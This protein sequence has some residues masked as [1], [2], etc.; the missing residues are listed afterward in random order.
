M[1][2]DKELEEIRRKLLE[3]E[4]EPPTDG[5]KNIKAEV[6]PPDTGWRPIGWFGVILLLL[7]ATLGVYYFLN[8][9]PATDVAAVPAAQEQQ[10]ETAAVVESGKNTVTMQQ[11]ERTLPPPNRAES[12][13]PASQRSSTKAPTETTQQEPTRLR[14]QPQEQ[15]KLPG[16][17]NDSTNPRPAQAEGFPVLAEVQDT[18]PQE[19][20]V[21]AKRVAA[22]SIAMVEDAISTG[23]IP[24]T[25]KPSPE[26]E[27]TSPKG[28]EAAAKNEVAGTEDRLTSILPALNFEAGFALPDSVSPAPLAVAARADEEAEEEP[29]AE[30][31]NRDKDKQ[32]RDWYLGLTVAPRYAFRSFTPA[33]ADE[34]YIVNLK[35]REK[36]DPERMGYEF[37][38]TM[39]RKLKE[40]L[41]LET[42]L[43]LMQLRENLAYTYSNGEID[44]V[45]RSLEPDGAIRLTPVLKVVD[46]QLKSSYAYGGLRV[47]LT[48]FFLERAQSRFNLTAAAGANLLVRGR[49]NEYIDGAWNET[50][51]FPSKDNILEQSNY[52]LMLGAGYNLSLHSKYELMLMPTV[53]YFLGSTFHEREPFGLRPY[54]LGLNVQIRRSF[55]R[56]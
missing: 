28:R 43:S 14:Q 4:E 44:S 32:Q 2:T 26:D 29:A 38:L 15:E 18:V 13:A 20:P 56:N 27:K 47:G 5:W 11:P 30:T 9:T 50:I 35:N 41:Y 10:E 46:R 49:T 42:S 53:N 52:N 7:L 6:Q 37:N 31:K 40:Q 23:A 21:E 33:T 8:D 34:I 48:Y 3:L 12:T 17:S 54:S 55:G 36:L 1:L 22:E 19:N 25:G 24:K 51:V 45:V 39:G 16:K